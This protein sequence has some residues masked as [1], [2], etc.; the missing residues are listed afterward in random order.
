MIENEMNE[1]KNEMDE[2]NHRQLPPPH[3]Y[4]RQTPKV[5]LRDGAGPKA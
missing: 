1:D 5:L 2:D 3:Q 4:I